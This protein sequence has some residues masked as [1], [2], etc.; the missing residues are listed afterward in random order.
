MSEKIATRV[1]YGEALREF[2]GDK[3]IVVLDADL[4]VCTMTYMFAEKYPDRFYNIGIAEAN[5]AG[6]AAG[7]ATTGKTVF[8]NSFAMFST[9]R[10]YDQ[11]RNSIAYP[12]LNVKVIGAHAGVTVGK[13]GATHE[14]LED[15]ALM[16]AIP[17]MVVLSPCDANETRECVKAMIA[18]KGPCYMRMGRLAV[19][20]V[21]N[22]FENYSFELGKASTLVDGKD[23][24][25]IATGLLVAQALKAQKML[26]NEGISARVVDMHTI[27]PIDRDCIIKAANETGAIV[28]AEEHNIL[29][30]L[31]GAVAEVVSETVPVPVLR[32][33]TEDVFGHSGDPDELIVR[34]GLTPEHI[35]EKVHAAIAM[36]K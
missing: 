29:G 36:K 16:R 33:G 32:V 31:G 34:Y 14:C 2:G 20:Q 9:G 27:K 15:I 17:N 23:V 11:I 1:A 26:E 28:T 7:L 30:G 25:I 22:H 13:D 10:I 24:T 18:H 4:T 8:I 35:V 5:M 6:I 3:N 19:E 21:T 12:E